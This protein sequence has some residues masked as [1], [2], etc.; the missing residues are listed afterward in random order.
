M[1]VVEFFSVSCDLPVTK[2]IFFVIGVTTDKGKKQLLYKGRQ[3]QISD[4]DKTQ[5]KSCLVTTPEPL[6]WTLWG[7]IKLAATNYILNHLGSAAS[8]T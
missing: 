4:T 8:G 1:S 3:I 7:L 5:E 2:K 6:L